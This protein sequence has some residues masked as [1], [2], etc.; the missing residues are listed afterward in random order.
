MKVYL[1]DSDLSEI[2]RYLGYRGGE[3]D[4]KTKDDISECIRIINDCADARMVWRL[5]ALQDLEG[6]LTL[7]D[8][9]VKLPGESIRKHLNGA[10]EAVLLAVTLG[11]A[12]DGEVNRLMVTNPAKGVV[13][14]ACGVALV[15]KAADA[16]QSEID[17]KLNGPKTG[18]RFSPGY[19]DLPLSL[20]ED[21][22]ALLDTERKIGVR[23]NP[24]MLM[25]PTKSITAIAALIKE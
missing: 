14:N 13:L 19:G 15:E 18:V 17:E 5:F 12:L 24:N 22:I 16:L 23:L 8:T 25:N 21:F 4:E 20:Q 2:L 10:S 1:D 9:Y 7:R 11:S 6:V 3:L